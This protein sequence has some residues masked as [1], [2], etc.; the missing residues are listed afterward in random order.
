MAEPLPKV[1]PRIVCLQ[2]MRDVRVTYSDWNSSRMETREYVSAY[3]RVE[4]HEARIAMLNP[5]QRM[6]W[7]QSERP[8]L[9]EDLRFMT[10]EDA[11][12]QEWEA[13]AMRLMERVRIVNEHFKAGGR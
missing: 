5:E 10:F 6:A 2:C 7:R 8:A 4:C 12:V 3:F 9:W 11:D 13:E 1:L